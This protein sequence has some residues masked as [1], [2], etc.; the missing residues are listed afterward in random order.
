[1]IQQHKMRLYMPP[2]ISSQL[3]S[4]FF[5]SIQNIFKSKLQADS[6]TEIKTTRCTEYVCVHKKLFSFHIASVF[7]LCHFENKYDNQNELDS[8]VE[9][10][11]NITLNVYIVQRW[12]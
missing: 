11:K 10:S 7:L 9:C 6:L 3:D 8:M 2:W 12:K 5:S 4:R 1:M